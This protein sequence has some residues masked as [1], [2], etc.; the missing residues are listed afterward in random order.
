MP[1]RGGSLTR[2]RSISES[3][4][5]SVSSSLD[6][7]S[8]LLESQPELLDSEFHGY[9]ESLDP[10]PNGEEAAEYEQQLHEENK[11][12]EELLRRFS[13]EQDIS[14]W[15]K[16]SNCSLK[17]LVTKEECR[18]CTEFATCKKLQ[19]VGLEG[20]IV[21]HPGFSVN[22]LNEWVLRTAAVGLKTRKKKSYTSVKSAKNA[23]ESEF[24]RSV[25]YRQY[26]RLVYECVGW[27]KRA[28]LPSCVYNKIREAFPSE[29]FHGFEEDKEDANS[30]DM[31]FE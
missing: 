22:C 19:E 3:E 5:L 12:E 7:E 31:E 9:D 16:C 23:S 17:L 29:T 4:E 6:S 8:E 11:Q 18:C 24:L 14:T 30:E 15:F 1:K 10:V 13:R 2:Q 25:A 27:S 26:V 20:C 28:S 21:D